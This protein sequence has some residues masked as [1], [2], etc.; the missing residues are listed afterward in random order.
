M[1]FRILHTS[2]WHLGQHF[3]GKSRAREH[4][5]FIDWLLAQV[6][7]EQIDAVIVA[8]DIFDTGTPPSYARE[9]Y[10]KFIVALHKRNCAAVILAGN[11]DSVAMLN[12]SSSLLN[13]LNC[14][15][16]VKAQE[17]TQ[18]PEQLIYLEN[19]QQEQA[20][21][22]AVPFIRP[23]DVLTST[24]GQTAKEKQQ[25]LQYA[26]AQHYQQ[27]VNE[28]RATVPSNTAVIAT[29]HLTTVGASC[30]DSVRDIYIGTLDAFPASEFP[31]VD[32]L[33]L[34]H[35]HRPQIIGKQPHIRYC[36]SPIPLSFDETAQPKNVNVVSFEQG[37]MSECKPVEIPTFQAM[38]TIKTSLEQ[39][40]NKV[41]DTLAQLSLEGDEKLWLDI[42]LSQGDYLLDLTARVQELLADYP[43]DI[44]L[45][46]KTKKSRFNISQQD[47]V[48]LEELKVDDVFQAR[49]ALEDWSNEDDLKQRLTT[50]F[51]QAVEQ[52][53]QQSTDES[54]QSE[55]TS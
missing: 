8:G 24:A 2:D 47:N 36:G 14:H 43:V 41:A 12:E 42:E 37:K 27:L 21:V 38:A 20:V 16:V 31:T 49:L 19:A 48:T 39:L 25:Q 52:C 18:A 11:H 1:A 28:A 33:A 9:L 46:R 13:T 5:Q 17:I 30:S 26:I 32:Y 55:V 10:F 40:E 51:N 44:L 53:E 4:Q 35:I 54:E 45:V 50:L 29:G 15:V 3:Y 7:K 23:R 22:C 34:G 6:E